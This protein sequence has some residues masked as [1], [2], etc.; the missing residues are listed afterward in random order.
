METAD[1]ILNKA[2]KLPE[3]QRA[4][5]AEKLFQSLQL[6]IDEEIENAWKE[7]IDKRL[8]EIELGKVNLIDWDDVKKKFL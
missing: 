2:L 1:K 5:I 4:V 8:E 3:E 7:E 6:N